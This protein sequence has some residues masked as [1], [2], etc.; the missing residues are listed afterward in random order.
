VLQRLV[1]LVDFA[2]LGFEQLVAALLEAVA[3][4][5]QAQQHG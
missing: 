1:L 2:L 3:V 5:A 4:V